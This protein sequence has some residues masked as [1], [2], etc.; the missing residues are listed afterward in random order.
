MTVE[1]QSGY[2][3]GLQFI[4]RLK[5]F[6]QSTNN[7]MKFDISLE[8]LDISVERIWFWGAIA[9]FL[10]GAGFRYQSD[11]SHWIGAV[12]IAGFFIGYHAIISASDLKKSSDSKTLLGCNPAS[13]MGDK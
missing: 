6:T 8:R 1:L 2:H 7:R 5:S 4:D 10:L 12:V 9:G 11:W 3:V 13:D